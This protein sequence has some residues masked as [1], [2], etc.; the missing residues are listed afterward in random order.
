MVKKVIFAIL[1]SIL[2]LAVMGQDV[3]SESTD[4]GLIM[5]KMDITKEGRYILTLHFEQNP[6]TISSLKGI[7][8]TLEP[9][10]E[11]PFVIYAE[12]LK[13]EVLKTFVGN[14]VPPAYMKTSSFLRLDP[15][16]YYSDIVSFTKNE[17]IVVDYL[18]ENDGEL[19]QTPG[20]TIKVSD[21]AIPKH[22]L[23]PE[24]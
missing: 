11:V 7:K 23:A 19:K 5:L 21:I 15:I 24:N 10:G 4:A 1:S 18:M 6:A 2:F 8:V 17:K 20:P 14:T 3:V 12:D 16:V 13:E 9:S 22:Q